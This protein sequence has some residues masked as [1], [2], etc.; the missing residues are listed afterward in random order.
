MAAGPR[1]RG[2]GLVVG[3]G[4]SLVV[5]LSSHADY[6]TQKD[7][8]ELER[9]EYLALREGGTFAE[10]AESWKRLQDKK[11]DLD[12]SHARRWIFGGLSAVLYAYNLVDVLFL[13]GAAPVSSPGVSFVP[14]LG[15]RAA[16]MALVARF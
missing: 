2:T 5:W 15:E 1:Y 10:A 12:A 7:Q 6:E 9:E 14:V 11:D 3:E 4:A 13:D 8:F 16:G